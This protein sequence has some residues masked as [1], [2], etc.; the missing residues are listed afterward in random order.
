MSKQKKF[1]FVSPDSDLYEERPTTRAAIFSAVNL[2]QVFHVKLYRVLD[3][4]D[5]QLLFDS[6]K[7]KERTIDGI[8]KWA[9][10]GGRP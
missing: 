3:N 6:N 9:E 1:H 2:S 7:C 8:L 5:E 4:G 10:K